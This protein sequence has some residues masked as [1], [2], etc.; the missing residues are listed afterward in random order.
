RFS[1][2]G[3]ICHARDKLVA[4]R[5]FTLSRARPVLQRLALQRPALQRPA[6]QS[7]A[8]LDSM[9]AEPPR[10]RE[11][12]DRPA[13]RVSLRWPG[14]RVGRAARASCPSPS[15][16]LSRRQT[17]AFFPPALGPRRH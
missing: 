5:V 4:R 2:V 12:L 13:S 11:T 17:R 6:L 7:P 10:R 8:L 15:G 9:L 14:P 1:T 16:D 3:A